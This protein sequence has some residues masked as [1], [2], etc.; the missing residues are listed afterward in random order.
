M[1]KNSVRTLSAQPSASA[2][3]ELM[4]AREWIAGGA[5][6]IVEIALVVGAWTGAYRWAG[7]GTR[8]VIAGIIAV[9]VLIGIW[10][11]FMSPKADH[12]LPLLWRVLLGSALAVVIGVLLWRTEQPTFGLIL[13]GTG[14]LVTAIAQP[15]LNS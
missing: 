4:T 15:L 8:G 10:S 3:P 14:V 2:G 9:V 11:T 7:G 5:A 13:A 1:T 12:R 6:F